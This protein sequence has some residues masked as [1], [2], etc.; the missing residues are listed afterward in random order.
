MGDFERKQMPDEGIKDTLA[1][2]LGQY[3]VVHYQN[4]S[5]H[6]RCN[7]PSIG[8]QT[9]AWDQKVDSHR[10]NALGRQRVAADSQSVPCPRLCVEMRCF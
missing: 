4:C 8:V 10:I 3:A 7:T 6:F 5:G 1:Q 9:G 2:E